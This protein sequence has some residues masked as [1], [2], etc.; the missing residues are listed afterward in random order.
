[1]L[2]RALKCRRP[3]TGCGLECVVKSVRERVRRG[4]TRSLKSPAPSFQWNV[5][6]HDVTALIA[7]MALAILG[8]TGNLGL[9]LA[10]RWVLSG[11][12]VIIGSRSADKAQ[13]AAAQLAKLALGR[14]VHGRVSGMDNLSAAHAADIAVLTVPF[15]HQTAVLSEVKAA[16]Q[17]KILLDATAP[18]LP[19]KV[20]RVQLPPAGCAGA[21]SQQLLGENVKVVT[22]FQNVA[23]DLL[24]SDAELDCD[25]LVC[26]D[27]KNAR[28]RVVQLVAAAGMRGFHAGPLANSAA[29]DALTSVLIF[30]NRYYKGHAGIRLTG[31]GKTQ[32]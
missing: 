13:A 15:S 10:R 3:L 18:L 25:V 6:L 24:Q 17:G 31:V 23:A 8:G 27:D 11:N 21:I 5:F 9:G 22:S 7:S 16:L 4:S 19:P 28:E 29:A 1:L 14:N 20:A 30:I 12:E 32:D 26:G 2:V